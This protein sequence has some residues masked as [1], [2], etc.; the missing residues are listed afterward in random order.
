LSA[1]RDAFE[2]IACRT[3]GLSAGVGCTAQ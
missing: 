1:I 2:I 3:N